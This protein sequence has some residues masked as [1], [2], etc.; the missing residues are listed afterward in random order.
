MGSLEFNEFLQLVSTAKENINELAKSTAVAKGHKQMYR[1]LTEE[2]TAKILDQEMRQLTGDFYKKVKEI[3]EQLVVL[4]ANPKL[5]KKHK[6]KVAHVTALLKLLS[7]RVEEYNKEKEAF[8]AMKEERTKNL[9]KLANPQA[10]PEQLEEALAS[11]LPLQSDQFQPIS[12]AAQKAYE[13]YKSIQAISL[14]MQRLHDISLELET[15]IEASS[16]P[17]DRV[18]ITSTESKN[19]TKASTVD[20]E[21]A[22]R[23]RKRSRTIK[24]V[25]LILLLLVCGFLAVHFSEQIL[26]YLLKIKELFK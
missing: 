7:T 21:Q 15:I 1:T 12:P 11:P 8:D 26:N 20:L 17:L 13:E 18:S 19:V 25:F 23:R 14:D 5:E 3:K 16:L 4:G 10:T 2:G 6:D 9:Y 24:R 22:I